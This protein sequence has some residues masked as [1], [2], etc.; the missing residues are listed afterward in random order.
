M[1]PY[2]WEQMKAIF[3]IQHVSEKRGGKYST[4]LRLN[5]EPE[6]SNVYTVRHKNPTVIITCS[7]PP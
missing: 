1:L 6:V 7:V 5:L 3:S 4:N 2:V